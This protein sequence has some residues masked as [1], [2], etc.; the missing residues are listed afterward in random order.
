[1]ALRTVLR[2]VLCATAFT[3]GFVQ[4]GAA[5]DLR[6]NLPAVF[7]HYPPLPAVPL[8]HPIENPDQVGDYALDWNVSEL[9]ETYELQ[10]RLGQ[11]EWAIVYLGVDTAHEVQG[12]PAGTYNYRVRAENAY[13]PG[14]WSAE[15]VT[16]VAGD[17][18]GAIA[19]PPSS[20]R[21]LGGQALVSVTN[22]CPYALRLEFAGPEPGVLTLP[23]CEGCKVYTFI[24][25]IFCPT[26][27]RPSDEILVSP[28]SYRVYVS[29]DAA[30]VRPFVGQWEL[31]GDRRYRLCFYVLRR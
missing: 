20:G 19:R 11:G 18:P 9:A 15:Q 29:V 2:V 12:R 6:I 22:D 28:G 21:D 5:P 14:S 31:E 1:M 4:V 10:E 7:S 16:V 17:E 26:S 27:G 24:G 30:D 23:R 13:G 8:L 3:L 25:P